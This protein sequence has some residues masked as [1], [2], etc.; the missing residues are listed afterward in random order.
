MENPVSLIRATVPVLLGQFEPDT[1][2]SAE[3]AGGDWSRCLA[4]FN[5]RRGPRPGTRLGARTRFPLCYLRG[6][7]WV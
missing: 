7:H 1:R 3:L 5:E 2:R 6:R 4:I